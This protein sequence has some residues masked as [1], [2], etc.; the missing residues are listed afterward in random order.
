MRVTASHVPTG[1]S[2]AETA[3]ASIGQNS[4]VATP[5][6]MAM[7]SAAIANGG[8][9][10]TPYLIDNVST[11]DFAV[12]DQTKPKQL[13]QAVSPATAQSL[14]SMM[15]GVVDSGTGKAAR[16]SGV[17][18]A[19]KTGTAQNVPGQA[20]HAWFTGFAPADNP[21]VAVAVIVEH[22][23]NLADEAT[24]GAVAAPIARAVMEAILQ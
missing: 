9:L 6:Q 12:I 4:V 3:Q 2:K 22:G 8:S 10:M 17:K 20:P 13:S 16:I 11:P 7:V 5:L 21:Q 24:G 18:V 1:L 15:L 19:G 14:T 23:G